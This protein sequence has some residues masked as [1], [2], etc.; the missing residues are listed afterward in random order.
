M[1][2]LEAISS[3]VQILSRGWSQHC[4]FG[5]FDVGQKVLAAVSLV[6]LVS[7]VAKFATNANGA[8]W[9][10]NLQLM[11]VAPSGGQFCY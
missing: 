1:V 6:P 2:L 7:L 5:V 8:I 9:W 11:K 3:P 10:P 4:S